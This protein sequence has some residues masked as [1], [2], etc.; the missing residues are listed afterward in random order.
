MISMATR[1]FA[2]SP[3]GGLVEATPSEETLVGR[4]VALAGALGPVE[5]LVP[6][7]RLGAGA[8]AG[9]L[10]EDMARRAGRRRVAHTLA[11]DGVQVPV[12]P[13]V[14]ARAPALTHTLAGVHVHLLVGAA[15][16]SPV[17]VCAGDEHTRMHAHKHKHKHAH[18]HKHTQRRADHIAALMERSENT[19]GGASTSTVYS[20]I[21]SFSNWDTEPSHPHTTELLSFQTARLRA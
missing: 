9:V 13:T 18:K 6:G 1:V 15:H 2:S 19:G 21:H 14:S 3:A 12:G 11:A 4:L 8:L 5:R 7:T 20:R 10:V 16:V 17:Q